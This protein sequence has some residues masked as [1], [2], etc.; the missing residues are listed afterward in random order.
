MRECV[1]EGGREGGREGNSERKEKR[2]YLKSIATRT[3]S[4][5]LLNLETFLACV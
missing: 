4:N 2:K 1:C 3:L 5:E